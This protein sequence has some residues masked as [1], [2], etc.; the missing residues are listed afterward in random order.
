M[1]ATQLQTKLLQCSTLNRYQRARSITPEF[2]RAELLQPRPVCFYL[3]LK[4]AYLLYM[5]YIG[6]ILIFP[7]GNNFNQLNTF[8][9]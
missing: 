1:A 9:L 6:L 4:F 3:Y 2:D 7:E 5:E 8:Y